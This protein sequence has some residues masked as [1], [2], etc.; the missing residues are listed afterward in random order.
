MAEQHQELE[1][2]ECMKLSPEAF[3]QS[4]HFIVFIFVLSVFVN[5]LM[6]TGPLFMMQIYDRVLGS[7]SVETL[8]ALFV[9]VLGLYLV[10]W[11]IDYSRG[12]LLARLGSRVTER[13][14]RRVFD[15]LIRGRSTQ[16][17]RSDQLGDLETVQSVFAAPL[18]LAL[19]DI[20]W[21]PFF[22]IAIF[23]LHPVLGWLALAG[24]GTL[25]FITIL[26]QL[27]SHRHSRAS[28]L[29]T[30]K[31]TAFAQSS[32]AAFPI[33]LTQG[34]LH[35]VR[36]RWIK[37]RRRSNDNKMGSSDVTGFFS[38]FS[39]SFRLFLQ[40]AMLA[41][42][43]YLVLRGEMTGGAIIAGSILL[44]RG[45]QPLE[46]VLTGWPRLQNGWRS[47]RSLAR[48]VGLRLSK[49]ENKLQIVTPSARLTVNGVAVV[50]P[51]SE[52]PVLKQVTFDL[53]S[54]DVLGVIGASG[55]GKSSLA[56]VMVGL[57]SPAVG[58]VKLSGALIGQY[59]DKQ[60]GDLIGYLPQDVI[61]LP[62]TIADNIARM[63][64]QPDD[65]DVQKA[66]QRAGVHDLI[67][68][69]PEGY[70][71]VLEDA[72]SNL[73]GGQRQ[74]IALA[75]AFYGNP[76][77]YVLDEPNSALDSDGVN[78]L[79]SA[80]H[81]IARSGGIVVL[82]THRPTVITHCTKLLILRDGQMVA[83]GPKDEVLKKHINRSKAAGTV[84]AEVSA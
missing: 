39:K 63:D 75:R 8:T 10:M 71:T 24:A 26:T 22:F 3:A 73:S 54:G 74:R 30:S 33:I 61:L 80:I 68:S 83:Y 27:F 59:D 9:L 48:L 7:G 64:A 20:P 32:I 29:E 50:P 5:L 12:R 40:S 76:L 43:A 37:L 57:W 13:L 45:L 55:S 79:N 15:G 2:R 19:C 72:G 52:A 84:G 51:K 34:M 69:L 25:V 11:L 35:R 28:S 38:S 53:K 17:M 42:G 23:L 47:W 66:A 78:A 18:L 58:E 49:H 14:D 77:I 65:F 67:K 6:L 56:R 41:A 46:Q 70:N 31:S 1:R 16:N 60:L 36:E 21:T 81:D 62:G 4:H 44:G 82:M